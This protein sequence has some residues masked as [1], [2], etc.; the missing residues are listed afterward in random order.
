ME[1]AGRLIQR[2]VAQ[3]V[4]VMSCFGLLAGCA[5]GT[6]ATDRAIWQLRDQYVKVEKKDAE[7]DGAA[8]VNSHP[9]TVTAE[10][11]RAIL[12]DLL[13]RSPGE[14]DSGL[15]NDDELDVLSEQIHAGLL[16]A[17]ADED[18][19]FAIVGQYRSLMGLK[20]RMVTTGRIF[21][22]DGQLNIIFGNLHR[23]LKENEDRRLLPFLAGKRTRTA[24][25]EWTLAARP[26]GEQFIRKR[27]DWVLFSLDGPTAPSAAPATPQA[28]RAPATM[29]KKAVS[30][31]K[32]GIGERLAILNDLHDKKLISDEEYRL[33]RLE[34]LNE[35]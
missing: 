8:R 27:S 10:R 4:V 33:K 6:V 2:W 5:T 23:P 21:A 35:L 15:F 34:I 17:A 28:E 14:K 12:D 19:T 22:N 18:V 30:R 11:L 31:G 29:E 24:A 3:G 20:Q 13:I 9:A 26:G 32:A 7:A 25:S 1:T 16:S